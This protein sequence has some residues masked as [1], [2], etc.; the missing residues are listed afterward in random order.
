M[1]QSQV[2]IYTSNEKNFMN[3]Y[4]YVV[5]QYVQMQSDK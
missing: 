5:Q 3:I 4:F 1:V 2:C